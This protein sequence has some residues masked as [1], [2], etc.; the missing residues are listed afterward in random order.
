MFPVRSSPPAMMTKMRPSGKTA[1]PTSE[2]MDPQMSR[3]RAAVTRMYNKK[4]KEMYAPAK[5]PRMRE[6]VIGKL[7]FF[8]PVSRAISTIF[9]GGLKANRTHLISCLLKKGRELV[10]LLE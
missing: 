1:A 9:S 6:R 7:T 3:G 2:D 8:T 10:L 4:P 5:K